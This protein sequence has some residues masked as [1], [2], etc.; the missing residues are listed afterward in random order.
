MVRPSMVTANI[1]VPEDAPLILAMSAK[2]GASELAGDEAAMPTRALPPTAL[3]GV[4][5]TFA[6]TSAMSR[7]AFVAN[8]HASSVANSAARRGRAERIW[9][10]RLVIFPQDRGRGHLRLDNP[11]FAARGI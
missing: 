3:T 6:R 4:W 11:L 1:S 2:G 7:K 8:G 10:E 9:R 5:T